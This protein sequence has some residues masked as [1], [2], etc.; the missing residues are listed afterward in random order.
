MMKI[1]KY[2]FLLSFSLFIAGCNDTFYSSIPEAPVNFVCSLVQS[3]Y[4]IV[5]S[6]NQF[7]TVKPKAGGFIGITSSGETVSGSKYGVYL[8]YAGLVI[9]NSSFNGYCAFDL[10]CPYDYKEFNTKVAVELQVNGVGKAICP[11]CKTEYDLNNGGIP[12]Q[13]KSN[14]RLKPYKV[15]YS[16][17]ASS[18]GQLTV[19]N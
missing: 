15:I 7:F 6:P 1:L 4:Y 10:A 5:T 12:I 19:R 14:E 17:D 2:I 9:G 13:G 18:S 16:L 3:P 8:G 11:K